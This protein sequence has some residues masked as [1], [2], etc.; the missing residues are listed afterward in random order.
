MKFDVTLKS[1]RTDIAVLACEGASAPLGLASAMGRT[2]MAL[3][4]QDGFTGKDKD[5]VV[6]KP[7]KTTDGPQFARVFMVGLGARKS[8]TPEVLRQR[9]A[10]LVKQA[11]SLRITGLD[12]FLPEP[13]DVKFGID[14]AVRAAVE[15]AELATYQFLKYKAPPEEKPP[16]L[17]EL[18]LVL[19]EKRLLNEKLKRVL[20]ETSSICAGVKFSRNLTNEPANVKTPEQIGAWA[21]ELAMPGRITV[22]VYHKADIEKMG[23]GGLLSVAAGSDQPPVFLHLSYVPKAAK[24]T[25]VLVGKGLTFDSGGLNIKTGTFMNNMKDDMSGGAAVLGFFRA[26]RTVDLGVKVHGLVPLTENMSGGKAMKVGDVF[27]AHNGKT[28]EVLNTDAEG[29]LILADAL[30]YGAALKPDLMIDM[31]TLTGACVVALGPLVTGALGTSQ[32]TITRL[33]ELGKTT[34]EEFWQLPLVELYRDWGKSKIADINNIGKP[35]QGGTIFA[36]L[37]LQEF[38]GATPWVHLDIAGTAFTE[39]E[40][41]YLTPGGTGVPIRTLFALL[42]GF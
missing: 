16:E 12:L 28:V 25:V 18:S 27:K 1:T 15:A 41:G 4:V 10:A 8:F 2:L 19:P 11:S 24:K 13:K 7:G 39:E 33:I 42:K 17:E 20:A 30:A 26:L 35:G 9:M 3:A 21:S 22:K 34:G 23:M 36:G 6:V 40:K 14:N 5:L 37:F 38:V 32:K 29:R 31:A